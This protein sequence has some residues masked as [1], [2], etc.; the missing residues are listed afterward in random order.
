MKKVLV[1]DDEEHL[2]SLVKAYLVKDGY[3]VT[4]A[5]N[6]REGLAAVQ[7][8]HPD[9]II[10]DIMMPEMDGYEF[11][12]ILRVDSDT[13]VIFLTAK[14]DEQER[15]LGLELG[16]DDYIV[17]PFY[18]RE[19][20]SRV[21]AVL[22]RQTK[23]SDEE[24][25]YRLGGIMMDCTAHSVTVE[26]NFIDLTPSPGR[27]FSRLDLLDAVQGSRFDGYERTIDLHIKNLRSKLKQKSG[28]EKYIETVYGVGYRFTRG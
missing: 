23:R 10:L 21:R 11:I 28:E 24:Q 27:V 3:Q 7:R 18:P 8:V 9:L 22:R 5:N 2:T 19:L 6:G 4:I 14:V 17:K 20:I 15:V 12:R 26:G 1:I 16:A 25:I 13:P